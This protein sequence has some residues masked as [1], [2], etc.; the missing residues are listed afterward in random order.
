MNLKIRPVIYSNYNFPIP[1][2]KIFEKL[3]NLD[4]ELTGQSVKIHSIFSAQDNTPSMVIYYSQEGKDNYYRFKDF[5]S[6]EM[7]DGIDLFIHLYKDKLQIEDRQDAY[8]KLL[9]LFKERY[10]FE[11]MKA[12]GGPIVLEKKEVSNYKTRP[13]YKADATYWSEHGCTPEFTHEYKI[14]PLDF[15]EMTI[16][17]GS[18]S[19]KLS[20]K[21]TL[22]Y[23]YFNKANQL[24]KIYN[25]G[26][27]KG[28][29]LKVRDFI[30][31]YEQLKP[32]KK[33]CLIMASMKD[34]GAFIGLRFNEFN[35]IAPESENVELPEE[36]IQ[37][38]INT[39]DYVFTLMDNDTEGMKRML[40]Y[41]NKYN[42]PFI[43][44]D[45]QK[46]FAQTRKDYGAKS[47]IEFFKTTFIKA[48]KSLK[49]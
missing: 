6:G 25:P 7:G 4:E 36:I 2:G 37:E 19:R 40:H 9:R 32:G 41:K 17:K 14:V 22:C 31:G 20:F 47:T 33:Y 1:S 42:I 49:A 43:H 45:Y 35:C 15:Y 34:M 26:Q 13:W 27:K 18:E 10:S 48:L 46:D 28:K 8:Y 21:N 38:L 44:F 23:G 24:C 39:H 30:Q 29:F 12:V 3:L 16:S 11:E 5:S